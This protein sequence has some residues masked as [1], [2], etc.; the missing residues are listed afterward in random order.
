MQRAVQGFSH[1]MLDGIGE[2][3]KSTDLQAYRQVLAPNDGRANF[4]LDRGYRDA[5]DSLRRNRFVRISAFT[6]RS[7]PRNFDGPDRVAA[8]AAT[9]GRR[10]TRSVSRLDARCFLKN[11]L[12][13][14]WQFAGASPD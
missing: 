9:L 13:R 3:R 8:V 2:P 12:A 6:F 14:G 4:F 7:C 5:C 1:F 11:K 10:R